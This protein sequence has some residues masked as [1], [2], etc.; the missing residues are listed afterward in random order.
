MDLYN[1]SIDFELFLLSLYKKCEIYIN[2]EDV[3]HFSI[4]F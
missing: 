3:Y 2:F 1:F 4:D